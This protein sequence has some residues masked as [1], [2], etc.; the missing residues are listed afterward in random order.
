VAETLRVEGK[1]VSA[2]VEAHLRQVLPSEYLVVGQ[3]LI[4]GVAIDAIVVGPQGLF[5][6]HALDWEGQV[7]PST[8]RR[9]V[10]RT[11]A[12][13]LRRHASP[14]GAAKRAR[15]ALLR[16][17]KDEFPGLRPAIR[18]Y[19]VLYDPNATLAPRRASR[20]PCVTLNTLGADIQSVPTSVRGLRSQDVRQALALALEERRL[21]RSAR[22]AQPFIFR[23]GGWLGRGRQARSLKQVVRHLDRYPQDGV[24]HL[25]NGTLEQWFRE[26]GAL[27]LARLARQTV[28]D[29]QRDARAALEAF[30][31]GSGMVRRPR[32]VARPRRVKLGYV[33]EGQTAQA[34]LALRRG[35]GRGYLY[36]RV[37]PSAPW[38]Q[39]V[40][41][42]IEGKLQGSVTVDTSMLKIKREPWEG[43]VQVHSSASA[44]P[45][46][47]PVEVHVVPALPGVARVVLRPLLG[48][49]LGA[50][51]GAA[52]GLL[53][54]G[55]AMDPPLGLRDITD[56]P[57]SRPIA[58]ALIC[59]TL[60]GLVGLLR[61]LTWD[62]VLPIGVCVGRWLLRVLLWGLLLTA[63]GFLSPWLAR[64]LF[65]SATAA[66]PAALEQTI[67]LVAVAL[68]IVP[69]TW[70]ELLDARAN[71]T[72]RPKHR[73]LRGLLRGV[74][75]SLVVAALLVLLRLGEPLWERWQGTQHL[76]TARVWVEQRWEQ[77]GAWV[78]DLWG[79][80]YSRQNDRRAPTRLPPTPSPGAVPGEPD[81]VQ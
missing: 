53:L 80:A 65:P 38:V 15:R 28:Q 64:W 11:A 13:K 76:G 62:P 32:L 19:A 58:W 67:Q 61:G 36:G 81:V 56:P 75:A 45:I 44:E 70:G 18:Q 60:W 39:V 47:V 50:L 8:G 17:L 63:L 33:L 42:E 29:N 5:V 3:P 52:I 51:L 9:W 57:M 68:A 7:T 23:S 54:G 40:P 31:L 2:A 48:L 6:L 55:A 22:V 37:E 59:G 46:E 77:L 78:D 27:H 66:V 21:T 20:P 14:A 43:A 34:S 71:R 26:Q 1:P 72:A 74:A 25:R 12:G 4:C 79:E 10:E 16:F 49:L 41:T 24:Y 73:A 35:R 69:G 30:M